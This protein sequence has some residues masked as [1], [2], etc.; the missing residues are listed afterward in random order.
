[1]PSVS[2][3]TVASIYDAGRTAV[4][5]IEKTLD[6]ADFDMCIAYLKY[7]KKT[8]IK[9]EDAIE[10]LEQIRAQRK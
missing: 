3:W 2:V 1:M 10:T 7:A 8:D 4:R 9:L 6:N 5:C